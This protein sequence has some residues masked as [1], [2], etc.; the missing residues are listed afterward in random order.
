[1]SSRLP[2]IKL[3]IMKFLNNHKTRL[4]VGFLAPIFWGAGIFVF[5]IGF[6][7]AK[8]YI[9]T[10]PAACTITV[11]L[12]KQFFIAPQEW[13]QQGIDELQRGRDAANQKIAERERLVVTLKEEYARAQANARGDPGVGASPQVQRAQEAIF[14]AQESLALARSDLEWYEEKLK[15][16]QNTLVDDHALRAGIS[17]AEIQNKIADWKREAEAMWNGTSP[18]LYHCCQ[19]RFV[20]EYIFA[21]HTD[22]LH[23]D[24]DQVALYLSPRYRS[25]V[26]GFHGPSDQDG[27]SKDPFQHDMKA[28][29]SFYPDAGDIPHEAGHEM[30]LD[31][32]YVDKKHPDGTTYSES[33]PGHEHDLLATSDGTPASIGDEGTVVD[34]I[35]LILSKMEAA[36]PQPCCPQEAVPV[37]SPPPDVTPGPPGLEDTARAPGPIIVV[38]CVQGKIVLKIYDSSGRPV[39]VIYKQSLQVNNHIIEDMIGQ[40]NDAA[41]GHGPVSGPPLDKSKLNGNADSLIALYKNLSETEITAIA[42]WLKGS[43]NRG[44]CPK[45][46]WQSP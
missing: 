2:I 15:E 5:F 10:D 3:S 38:D 35:A 21:R 20:Y 1:M 46:H 41:A 17:D 31:D 29:F 7:E 42:N 22:P 25:K 28:S 12:H 43:L 45:A 19:V 26:S 27:F 18:Y 44:D 6:A 30:G 4:K 34:N 23:P 11:T 14:R 16:R 37:P 40:A 8:T 32:Q 13:I 39:A 33:K 9:E 24:H 36:C